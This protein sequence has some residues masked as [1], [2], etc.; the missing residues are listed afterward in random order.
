ML[1]LH[2]IKA[3]VIKIKAQAN[4]KVYSVS[5]NHK[6]D[7]L[8]S[9][10]AEELIDLAGRATKYR[11]VLRKYAYTDLEDEGRM[12]ARVLESYTPQ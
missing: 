7:M 9:E 5:A 10:H 12:A 11:G 8:L 3:L 4:R 6:L 1:N 2:K